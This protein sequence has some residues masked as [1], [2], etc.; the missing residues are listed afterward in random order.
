MNCKACYSAS[1]TAVAFWFFQTLGYHLSL[2][3]LL[4]SPWVLLIHSTWL[5]P[6]FIF[7]S[8]LSSALVFHWCSVFCQPIWTSLGTKAEDRGI[9]CED[10]SIFI[11]VTLYLYEEEQLF[12]PLVKRHINP[13]SPQSLLLSLH[14]SLCSWFFTWG[15]LNACT[16]WEKIKSQ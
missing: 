3:P 13:S 4:P 7:S 12:S 16:P 6:S 5:S 2:F 8:P 11:C 10:C 15:S 9:V 1:P 14:R